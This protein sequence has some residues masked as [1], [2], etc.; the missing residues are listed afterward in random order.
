MK[1][2]KELHVTP[3]NWLKVPAFIGLNMTLFNEA[4]K[5]NQK[6]NKAH[7]QILAEH[8]KETGNNSNNITQKHI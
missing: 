3:K 6:I 2:F 7:Q 4:I 1:L 5:S 8:K